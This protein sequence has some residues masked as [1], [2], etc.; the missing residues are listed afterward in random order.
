M[1]E[2]FLKVPN[3]TIAIFRKLI[4]LDSSP[5]HGTFELADYLRQQA[6]GLGFHCE[7]EEAVHQ[8]RHEANLWIR[9]AREFIASDGKDY[10]LLQTHL[11]TVEPGAFH[12]WSKNS[13]NPFEAVIENEQIFGIGT[14]ET[15][16]DFWCKI[17]ALSEFLHTHKNK[18]KQIPV[19]LGT[20][21]EE[22]G[23]AGALRA[24]R[25]GKLQ[26]SKALISEPTDSRL[27]NT[28]KG[29]ARIEIQVA[30]KAEEIEFR[31][32][33]DLKESTSTQSRMF[34]GKSAHSSH[35][36]E[37]DSAIRKMLGYLRYLPEG[38]VLMEMDGG[39]S[40]NSVPAQSFLELEITSLQ[41]TAAFRIGKIYEKLMMIETELSLLTDFRFNPNK[42]TINIGRVRTHPEMISFEGCFRWPPSVGNEVM[43]SWLLE[44][45]KVCIE[46]GATLQVLDFRRPFSTET[47]SEF[48]LDLQKILK[49]LSLNSDVESQA[50]ANEASLFSRLGIEC[51]CFGP[52]RKQGNVHTP[53]E[54]VALNDLHTAKEFYI[55]VLER[56]CL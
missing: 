47:T 7:L 45:K 39:E 26:F 14:A 42:A 53:F 24:I 13:Q 40:F 35:P 19:L 28:A 46:Q 49:A 6:E 9:P 10:L 38:V 20:Y 30:L 27:V 12:R 44:L 16:L 17:E 51:L 11:D 41:Q 22:N 36:E 54:H 33:H 29:F 31:K 21:G 50:S 48:V 3:E 2:L 15:K 56:Y 55:K 4:S 5:S 32:A 23:M 25:R 43:E 1:K 8:G 52:G 18:I 34:H 37:G